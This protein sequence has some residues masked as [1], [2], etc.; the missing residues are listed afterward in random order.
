MSSKRKPVPAASERTPA[1]VEA[2]EATV[3]EAK[4]EE[5]STDEPKGDDNPKSD[6][7]TG[8]N[9][10]TG[11]SIE[12]RVL[13]AFDGHAPNDVIRVSENERDRLVREGRLD[14]HPAAVEYAKG[15]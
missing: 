5:S 13:V 15:L 2:T 8:K 14:P 12:A 6:E 1:E 7:T 3:E 10:Q 9:T 4:V 11:E